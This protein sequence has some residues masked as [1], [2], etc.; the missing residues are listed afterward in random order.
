MNKFEP[1]I[2][3]ILSNKVFEQKP[4]VLIDIGASGGIF[5]KWA[6]FA[7]KSICIA[8]DADARDFSFD[9]IEGETGYR[10]LYKFNRIVLP[11]VQED[12]TFYLTKSPHCSSTLMPDKEGLKGYIFESLFEVEKEV[13]LPSTTID[14]C[15]E[16]VNLDYIDWY[17]V[18]SQGID[19]DIFLSIPKE[20]RETIFAADFEPGLMDAYLKENKTAGILTMLDKESYWISTLDVRGTQRLDE[21]Y[22]SF[23]N[24]LHESPC[25]VGLTALKKVNSKYD[26]RSALLLMVF[27]LVENQWGY[28]LQICEAVS[29]IDPIF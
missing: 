8:F 25:W 21:K 19:M 2:K 23:S 28:A 24:Q 18:D 3:S 17:K 20:I 9:A 13:R 14:E 12:C 6:L 5:D 15:L 1:I 7:D 22:A 4:P 29:K 10:K 27:S 16:S 26:L 11:N